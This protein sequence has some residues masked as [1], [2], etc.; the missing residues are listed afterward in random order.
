[1]AAIKALSQPT[2]EG[3]ERR[4]AIREAMEA[5]ESERHALGIEMNIKYTTADCAVYLADELLPPPTFDKDPERFYHE[6]TYPG[7]RLPHAWLGTDVM[8][9]LISTQDL[10]G[11]GRFTLFTGIGGKEAWGEACRR[12]A[13][14]I[15]GVEVKC[16]SVGWG[17]E[18]GDVLDMWEGKRG[19][20]EDGCVL[21]RPDRYVAWRCGSLEEMSVGEGWAGEKLVKVLKH[22]LKIETV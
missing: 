20:Q 1:M 14:E 9:Q 16:F 6:S 22:V 8:G 15:K 5:L 13:E 3:R 10:A 2:E 11:K 21:V 7:F 4:K 18:Y 12:V 19:V 17:Q